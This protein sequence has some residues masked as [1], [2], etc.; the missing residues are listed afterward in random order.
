MK[1]ILA[2]KNSLGKNIAFV[3][4]KLKVFLLIQI[5]ELTKEGK[6][7]GVYLVNRSTG[8]YLRSRRSISKNLQL[9][10]IAIGSDDIS[11]FINQGTSGSTPILSAYT[12]LYNRSLTDGDQPILK[13]VG[14]NLYASSAAVKRKILPVRRVIY[15]VAT[16]FNL[17]PFQI[18]AILIDEIARAAPF[19]EI[20]DCIGA[21]DIG[22]NTSVGLAQ[23]KIDTAN[24]IIRKK[25]Y[26]PNPSDPKL[27][28]KRLNRETRAYLYDYLIQPKH[29]IFFE[30]AILTDLINNWKG[31][32]DLKNHFNIL[33]TLYS[34]SRVPH[35]DPQPSDRGNQ[36]AGEFYDLAKEWIQ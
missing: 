30:G 24:N 6:I 14:S 28:L 12:I 19:E 15:E 21:K 9:D 25:L 10:R 1:I 23:I 31:F 36:I 34:L 8:S 2:V 26:N 33:A 27:P 7:E 4:D 32:I 3:T 13:P 35:V 11:L 5:L 18:G 17:D 29:N 20:I 22:A 16:Y